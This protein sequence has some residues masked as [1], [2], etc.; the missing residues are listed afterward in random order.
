VRRRRERGTSELGASRRQQLDGFGLC[1]L[2]DLDDLPVGLGAAAQQ[3]PLGVEELPGEPALHR[4][5]GRELTGL[6]VEVL[7]R[8]GERLQVALLLLAD[9]RHERLARGDRLGDGRR[10]DVSGADRSVH[11][12]SDR[13]SAG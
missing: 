9:S 1:I 11:D 3:R 2:G 7:A 12:P 10:R 6:A 8:L 5:D 4:G 13:T